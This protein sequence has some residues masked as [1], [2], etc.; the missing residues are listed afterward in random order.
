MYAKS[1]VVFVLCTLFVVGFFLV[2]N[3]EAA[4]V[5]KTQTIPT[6]FTTCSISQT[7]C[8]SF[9]I[10]SSSLHSVSYISE[11][12]PGNH[13]TLLLGIDVSGSSP[14]TDVNLFIGNTFAGS[15]QGPFEPG[16]NRVVNLTLPATISVSPGRTYVLS[17]EGFYGGG[18]EVWQAAEV[19]AS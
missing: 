2:L 10:T 14:V 17:V 12:G 9:S 8:E 4:E 3:Y 16:A 18:L 19:T 15:I 1:L 11:L 5:G 6:T 13:T 7:G